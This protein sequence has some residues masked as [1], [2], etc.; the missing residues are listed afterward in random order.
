MD[1]IRLIGIHQLQKNVTSTKKHSDTALRAD[2]VKEHK[3]QSSSL[4]RPQN[5]QNRRM[6]TVNV[7][8]QVTPQALLMLKLDR[9]T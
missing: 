9:T 4:P 5:S 2:P 1:V 7:S 8:N 6:S 3:A